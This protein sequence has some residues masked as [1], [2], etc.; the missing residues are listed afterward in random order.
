MDFR[1]RDTFYWLCHLDKVSTIMTSETG[2]VSRSVAHEAAKAI[3][4]VIA[5]AAVAGA[6]RPTD[7]LGV[8][9]LLLQVAGADG[10]RIHAGRSRQ[11]MLATVHRLQLRDRFLT[12]FGRLNDV[13]HEMLRVGS[14]YS[15]AIVPAYTNGVQA[16]PVT[17]GHLMTGYEA[18]LRRSAARMKET[19]QRLN[20]S[21]LGAAALAT[22]SF[23][24]D[25]PRLAK[26]L[27]FSECVEN[28]FDAAQLSVVD[29]GVEAASCACIIALSLGTFIQ[30]LHA[31]FHHARPWIL[32]DGA[33]LLSKSTLMPQKRNP[34]ALNRARLLASETAGDSITAIL[35]AHNVCSGLTDYKRG[36]A[37]HTLERAISLLG[38]VKSIISGITLD[39]DAAMAEIDA[40]YSTT[41]ELANV[42]QQRFDIPFDIGHH[43]ASALVTY[44]RQE[45]LG[46]KQIPFEQV[47]F[48]YRTAVQDAQ[49]P[50]RELPIDEPEF[51][52]VVDPTV[53]VET[54]VGLGGAQ[55]QEV[56]RMLVKADLAHQED[57]S[58]LA[59]S[60]HSLSHSQEAMEATFDHLTRY[61]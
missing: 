25:R 38:E 52:R 9:P 46:L 6:E 20:Q 26:L 35:A 30:D 32:L 36:D 17:F 58:W 47:C 10:S 3:A 44:G 29:V 42:L 18:A 34:V 5:D 12:L 22:S 43:F 51:R 31:Q 45:R 24:V 53:M 27:G 49:T 19:Y 48:L 21:P 50:W 15:D 37:S 8:Q 7:Y 57:V 13:R 55:P 61:G 39:T 54:Y 60:L 40:E 41:S 59:S 28:S 14:A 2:I 11:D 16:Q 23:A 33:N 1:D 4:K 56:R